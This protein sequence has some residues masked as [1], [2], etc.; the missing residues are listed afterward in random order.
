MATVVWNDGVLLSTKIDQENVINT[1]YFDGYM[2]D[3]VFDTD[4]G[5]LSGVLLDDSF[6]INADCVQLMVNHHPNSN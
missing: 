4:N 1:Y 3:V 5:N 6:N 2:V